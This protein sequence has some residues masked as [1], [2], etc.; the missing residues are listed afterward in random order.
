MLLSIFAAGSAPKLDGSVE[1]SPGFR[2]RMELET[3][4]SESVF[5]KCMSVGLSGH[6]RFLWR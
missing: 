4:S 3:C 2:F 5:G 1:S 6:R